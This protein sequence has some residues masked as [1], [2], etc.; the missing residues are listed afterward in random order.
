MKA[1]NLKRSHC[2]K[3]ESK[4]IIQ[5]DWATYE[6]ETHPDWNGLL[7]FRGIEPT[8]PDYYCFGCHYYWMDDKPNDGRYGGMKITIPKN[9][10]SLSI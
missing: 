1:I 10:F 7:H 2:S 4:N 8:L 5:I 3:C 6:I 9:G